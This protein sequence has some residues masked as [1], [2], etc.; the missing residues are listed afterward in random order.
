MVALF[1]QLLK[2]VQG[3]ADALA[4]SNYVAVNQNVSIGFSRRL[5][6][7]FAVLFATVAVSGAWQAATTHDATRS[8]VVLAMFGAVAVAFAA[9]AL[10]RRPVLVLDEQGLTDVRGGVS[11]RWQEIEAARVARRRPRC[12]DLV[13]TVAR[14]ETVRLSLDQLSRRSAEIARLLEGRTGRTVA[15]EYEGALRGRVRRAIAA[16]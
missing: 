11:V 3:R 13:L 8:A 14:G 9:Q 6:V 16:G 12:H 4:M 10:R 7:A 15:L 2:S 5:A 1:G